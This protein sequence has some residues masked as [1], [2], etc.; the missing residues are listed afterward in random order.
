M[1]HT[2]EHLQQCVKARGPRVD[3]KNL[4]KAD[5]HQCFLSVHSSLTQSLTPHYTVGGIG[6]HCEG[7]KHQMRHQKDDNTIR[8]SARR[9]AVSVPSVS[10]T[11]S[12]QDV[13]QVLRV[14]LFV[15][16]FKESTDDQKC[17]RTSPRLT[18]ILAALRRTLYVATLVGAIF[19]SSRTRT[20]SPVIA[21]HPPSIR[22]RHHH[23]QHCQGHPHYAAD[24]RYPRYLKAGTRGSPSLQH[25]IV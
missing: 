1:M 22:A 10:E 24:I 6:R 8:T 3:T 15:E 5:V 13:P 25:H 19:L 20:F 12:R 21:P 4:A 23:Y 7:R 18:C 16:L 11:S 9:W 14:K 17:T 2:R